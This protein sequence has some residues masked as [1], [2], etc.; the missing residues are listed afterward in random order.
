MNSVAFA[1]VRGQND[2]SRAHWATYRI[3]LNAENAGN[4]EKKIIS[5]SLRVLCALHVKTFSLT[6][7]K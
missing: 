7:L 4:A 6:Y 2:G 1:L 5:S 3:F